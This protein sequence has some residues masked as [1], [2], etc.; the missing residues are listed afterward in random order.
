MAK[1]KL[2]VLGGKPIG[3]TDIVSCAKE[4]G[5]YT[6]VADYL[7]PAESP[8]KM[9]SD[10]DWDI[11]ISDVDVLAEKAETEQ[12]DGVIAG[13]HEFCIRKGIELCQKMGLSSWCTLEQ[14]DNCSNKKA[15]KK[16]CT[17][18]GI[19]VAR[20]YR[21]DDPNIEFPV[22]VKPTDSDGSRGFSICHNYQELEQGVKNALNFSSDYLIE[23]YMQCDACL[24]HYTAVDGQIL[25]S[26]ISDKYSRQ[27]ENGSM[28]MGI[29][30]FPSNDEQRYLDSVN[31]KAI[32]MFKGIGIKNGPIWIE[33]FNDGKRFVFNEMALRLGGS[34]TNYPVK[35]YTGIDQLRLIVDAAVDKPYQGTVNAYNSEKPRYCILPIHTRPGKV[36]KISGRDELEAEEFVEAIVPVHFLGDEIRN[37]GT[38]QQVFYYVH[39]TF[40]DRD[41]FYAKLVKIKSTLHVEDEYGNE[42]LFYLMNTDQ[43]YFN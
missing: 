36:T 29:Q 7:S 10:A 39:F 22:I 15:F 1:Q 17:A 23:E 8:A 42:Q 38:A 18:N 2:L 5:L 37:W 43:L 12:I 28:V 4:N 9:L 32:R 33:A 41:D 19:D 27:L 11:S 16:L 20:T 25:F 40:A 34:M 26:G 3:S 14:W 6:I 21:L 35:Y 31:E 24:I 30:L 13:V